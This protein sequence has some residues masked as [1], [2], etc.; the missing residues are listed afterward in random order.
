M[1]R[2]LIIGSTIAASV[3]GGG[4]WLA[5]T[6][7][8]VAPAAPSFAEQQVTVLEQTAKEQGI[9]LGKSHQQLVAEE[10]TQD[11]VFRKRVQDIKRLGDEAEGVEAQR[12]QAKRDRLCYEGLRSACD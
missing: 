5:S 11:A 8:P 10:T 1:S 4:M 2:V 6:I 12:I 3:F 7:G 9:K